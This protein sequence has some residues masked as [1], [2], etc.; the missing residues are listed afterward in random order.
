MLFGVAGYA[1]Q[2]SRLRVLC[3]ERMVRV[4]TMPP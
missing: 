2:V 4:T 1:K 3:P